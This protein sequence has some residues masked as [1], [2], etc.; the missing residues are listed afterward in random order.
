MP[1]GNRGWQRR[2]DDCIA[3][4]ASVLTG[5]PESDDVARQI[6]DALEPCLEPVALALFRT[7]DRENSLELV[8]HRGLPDEAAHR[9]RTVPISDGGVLG[10]AARR[11][12]V[13]LVDLTVAT[14][15]IARDA[16]TE[17][18]PTARAELALPFIFRG[19]LLGAMEVVVGRAESVSPTGLARLTT[20]GRFIAVALAE[21]LSRQSALSSV[22]RAERA[23][24]AERAVVSTLS[25]LPEQQLQAAVRRGFYVW[26]QYLETTVPEFIANV[27]QHVVDEARQ[28]VGA[29]IAAIGIGDLPDR[30]FSPWAFSGVPASV[31]A[32]LG[33]TPR[34]VGTLGMVA[35]Q[36]EIV[37][38]PDVRRHPSF[39][40]LPPGHPPVGSMLGVPIRYRGQ[41]L[42]NL[43]LA[44]KIG[45]KEFSL[46]DQHAAEM[47]ANQAAIALQQGFLQASI[48]T[49]RAQTQ[50]LLDSAPHGILFVD[51]MTR[52][53]MANPSAMRLLGETVSPDAGIEQ[54]IERFRYPDGRPVPLESTPAFR[55][56][57]G[58]EHPTEQFVV[59]RRDGTQIPIIES[60]APVRGFGRK[61]LGA[62]VNFEDVSA[63]HD[64][65]RMRN[66]ERVRD[67]FNATIAHDLRNPI[68][69][70]LAQIYLL[71][72]EAEGDEV[73]VPV[74]ALRRIERSATTL[75]RMA[76]VL[77]DVSRIELEQIAL[78]RKPAY[79]P[80]LAAEI[81]DGM[82]PTLAAQGHTI[83][84][85]TEGRPPVVGLDSLA[86]E[87]I[88][89]NLIDNAAKFSPRDTPLR[90]SVR[91]SEGGALL[92]VR[93]QGP[94][95]RREDQARLFD[96]FYKSKG[97]RE[98]KTGLG[99]GLF[100]VKGY[101]EAHGGRV[102]VD[103]ELGRGATF[104]VWFPPFASAPEQAGA[105]A[106][107][108]L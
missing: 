72:R 35:C 65:E 76:S 32:A 33:R 88:L 75:G 57:E 69:T 50:S 82:R 56:L 68:Q 66:L 97:V 104:H 80:D 89:T 42:G 44:N 78:R 85:S 84:L 100:I 83:D 34:P 62:V 105:P 108:H 94:G 13:A 27:I 19:R 74:R 9:L 17:V 4:L 20:L 54:Y 52:R 14:P 28:L 55:A 106:P 67:E 77:L 70:V 16:M 63:V 47:L 91:S 15:G 86:F 59:T 45:A 101:V 22:A 18:H 8:E 7:N 12:D 103:S 58:E 102:T 23:Q 90:V 6:V 11:R 51:G 21:G 53:V 48:E 37:R 25:V 79:L 39:R 38:V 26:P 5:E 1:Y 46:Q 29:E 73:K 43:Y 99:L 40:G 3:A 61:L 2:A 98:R 10:D 36:G 92:S 96:R 95:I 30:P 107:G 87:Q 24:S 31:A 41:S 49:Q 71:L 93:D 60:A 64:V 81:L